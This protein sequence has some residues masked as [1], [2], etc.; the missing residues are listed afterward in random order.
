MGRGRGWVGVGV[1]IS[2]PTALAAPKSN[3][4]NASTPALRVRDR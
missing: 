1:G 2:T 3:A 4:A